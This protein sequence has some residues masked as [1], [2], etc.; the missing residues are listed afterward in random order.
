MSEEPTHP[1]P[2]TAARTRPAGSV[3]AALVAA[4]RPRQWVKNLLVLAALVPAGKNVVTGEYIVD[5]AAVGRVAVAF[6][7]FCVA[8]S[9][10]YLIA[11]TVGASS[12]RANSA[13]RYRPIAAGLVP[14]PVA[15]VLGAVLL[16]AAVLVSLA[17]SWQLAFVT[18]MF[19]AMQLSYWLALTEVAVIDICL[20]AG[21]FL[22]RAIAGGV[23]AEVRLSMWFLLV[24]AS[25]SVFVAAGKRY[26]ELMIARDTGARMRASLQYYTP[27]YLR[28][29]W[30]M[31]ATA[32]VVFYSLWAFEPA[33]S[34]SIWFE[35]SLIPF[36]MAVLR[37]AVSIDGAEADEPEE[38]ALHSARLQ[39]L[40][41]V[42]IVALL[43]AV[44]H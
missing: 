44:Y 43:I 25:G 6:A 40:A 19:I 12:D 28:F 33:R 36:T 29:V 17:V 37:Y 3:A 31:A 32:L 13:R 18:A 38:I 22:V 4:L 27:T 24:T 7:V 10:I 34:D 1:D 30:T 41:L 26:A 14:A 16:A 23:A 20:V 21:G 2:M 42:W 5:A 35:L 39:L 9:G 11:D 15:C 8:S